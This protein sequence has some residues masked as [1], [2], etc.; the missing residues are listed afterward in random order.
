MIVE[1]KSEDH[2]KL[3]DIHM[4][5]PDNISCWD[6]CLEMSFQLM[7]EEPEEAI[8]LL[9]NTKDFYSL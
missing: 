3:A 4:D 5:A 6:G 2:I 8:E 1:W 9:K 7:Q